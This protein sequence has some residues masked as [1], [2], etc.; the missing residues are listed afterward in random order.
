MSKLSSTATVSDAT[1]HP[2]AEAVHH[3]ARTAENSA[4]YLLPTLRVMREKNTKLSLLDVGAGSGSITA[5]LAK[6]IPDG[7]VTGV[8]VNPK[9]LPRARAVA[10]AAGV[11]NISFQEGDAKSL[12]FADDSFDIV[13]CHQVLTHLPAPWEALAEMLRVAK[14]GGI[15]AAREADYETECIWP[16][17]PVLSQFHRLVTKVMM[18]NGGTSTAGRQLISWAAKAGAPRDRVTAS[19][20]PWTYLSPEE[21]QIWGEYTPRSQNYFPLC[22]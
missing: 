10:E 18:S 17:V 22:A 20:S 1:V 21:R 19:F 7:Y 9:I 5:A 12:P 14:P 4:A 2:Q 3:E 8:D 15:V 16:D 6:Y 13:I 11:D